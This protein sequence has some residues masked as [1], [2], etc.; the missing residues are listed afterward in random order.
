M[1]N[2]L[3]ILQ[4][5]E[6]ELVKEFH[7]ICE[8]YDLKYLLAFGTMIGCARHHGF[9]PWDD[10]IDVVMP[11]EDYC[12]FIEI[13]NQV[14]DPRYM[15]F[16]ES[17]VKNYPFPFAKFVKKDSCAIFEYPFVHYMDQPIYIDIFPALLVPKNYMQFKHI[18]ASNF[19]L[20]QTAK[21]KTLSPFKHT[22]RGFF[23]KAGMLM[24]YCL[25]KMIPQKACY[26]RMMK[27]ALSVKEEDARCCYI[28]D[29]Y[30]T[31]AIGRCQIPADA[32]DRRILMPFEDTALYMPRD[33]DTILRA[34]YGDYM[35]L[36]PEDQRKSHGFLYVDD[37]LSYQEYDRQQKGKAD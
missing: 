21:M 27:T 18:Q 6:L 37:N 10:D 19:F 5:T 29:M 26:S 25:N 8:Q 9:I 28:G 20:S 13:A 34:T 14:S 7:G 36:P 15:V 30:E 2:Q 35:K 22:R 32:F 12:K 3:E 24:F 4:N 23:A 17:T 33:Y 1:R 16:H 31:N 11:W